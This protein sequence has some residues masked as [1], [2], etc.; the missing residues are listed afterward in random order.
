MNVLLI[1]DQIN[2]VK[3]LI[4]GVNWEKI[5]ICEIYKAF[6]IHEAKEIIRDNQVDIMVCDIEMPLGNGIELLEW[7]RENFPEIECIFLSAHPE[8]EY[9][10]AAIKLGSFDYLLQ[11]I[12]YDE[13]EKV[14]EKAIKKI[15]ET[16][17]K[18]KFYKYG[19]YLS[20]N[21]KELIADFQQD[22]MQMFID[23]KESV[24]Y[25]LN[26]K[27]EMSGSVEQKS[28]IDEIKDYISKNL[29]KE[30]SRNEIAESVHLNQEYLS[31]LFKKETGIALIDYII[32]ERVKVSK[33]LL[34]KTNIP[35]SIIASKVGYS[36]F[37]HFSKIFKRETGLTPLEY[38]QTK[39]VK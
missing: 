10:K 32:S 37:S 25:P 30:L 18:N 35:V 4:V 9:A 12:K 7:V 39:R 8:F 17:E 38:R 33:E 29:E 24:K 13:L 15:V 27:F 34:I 23:V 11:P 26:K 1:D 20:E 16:R 2:V 5:G 6:N 3:G 28:I 14:I 19:M 21:K 22:F 31:R 36:N